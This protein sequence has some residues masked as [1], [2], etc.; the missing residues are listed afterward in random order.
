[1]DDLI[2]RQT[3]LESIERISVKGNVLDDDWVYRFI[4]EFPSAQQEIIRCKDCMYWDKSWQTIE[5]CHYCGMIDKQTE[6]DFFCG[7]GERE[8][9]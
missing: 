1:M 7:D 8:E 2:S 4:Q 3:L 6:G 5:G 9:K